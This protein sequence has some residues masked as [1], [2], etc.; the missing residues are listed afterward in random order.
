V[1]RVNA[2][3]GKEWA[4]CRTI[5]VLVG[6]CVHHCSDT[7]LQRGIVFRYA[8]GKGIL[9]VKGVV[10]LSQILAAIS[11][12][13]EALLLELVPSSCDVVKTGR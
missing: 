12:K 3:L 1:L 11:L 5:C 4:I 13:E 6:V 8:D 9:R 2:V 7:A 10:L